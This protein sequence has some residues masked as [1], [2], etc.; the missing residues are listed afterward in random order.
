MAMGWVDPAWVGLSWVGS[1]I[2]YLEWIAEVG[3]SS[4]KYDSICQR[5]LVNIS[6][7][8]EYTS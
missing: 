4:V 2:F 8:H 3:S 1:R 5:A 7:N 6:C